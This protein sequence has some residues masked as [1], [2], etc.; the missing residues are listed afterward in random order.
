MKHDTLESIVL[1]RHTPILFYFLIVIENCSP[2]SIY[3]REGWWV[4][5]ICPEWIFVTKKYSGVSIN[6]SEDL[7]CLS[8]FQIRRL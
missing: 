4:W 7:K 5:Y 8:K 3:G 6:K 2:D 1:V